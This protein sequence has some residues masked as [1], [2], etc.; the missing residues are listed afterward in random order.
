MLGELSTDLDCFIPNFKLKNEDSEKKPDRV[1]TVVFNPH[2]IKQ[3]KFSGTP[4]TRHHQPA[5]YNVI[6]F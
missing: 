5:I 1:N 4:G 6:H 2:Q 3:R